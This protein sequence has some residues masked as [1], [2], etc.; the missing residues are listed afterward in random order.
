[1]STDLTDKQEAML[2]AI[3]DHITEFG[4]PPTVRKLQEHFQ[5]SSVNGVHQV[6]QALE[7]KGYLRRYEKGSARGYEVVGWRP[8]LEEK[9]RPVPLVGRIAAGPPITAYENVE[10]QIMVDSEIL[11]SSGD[12]ALRVQGSSMIGAGIHDGDIIIVQQTEQCR[13]GEIAVALLNDEATVKRFFKEKNGYRLQPENPDLE[14][15]YV[16]A[17]DPDFRLIGK[18]KALIRRF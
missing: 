6:L 12:F 3:K 17:N 16:A 4:F 2:E 9:I 14:P 18:V 8:E 15:I 13:N 5:Y 10:G 1:M 7:K 11:G